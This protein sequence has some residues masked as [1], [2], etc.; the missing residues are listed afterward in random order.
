MPVSLTVDEFNRGIQFWRSRPRWSQQ[1]HNEFYAE[2]A[3][4]NPNGNFTPQWWQGFLPRLQR[5]VA[6]PACRTRS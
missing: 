5:W 1:F 4:Q 6:T 3:T 2:L